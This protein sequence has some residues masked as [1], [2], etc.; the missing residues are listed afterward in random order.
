[1][2]GE[3]D[4]D[5]LNR[6][7]MDPI[8]LQQYPLTRENALE[9]FSRS[10]FYDPLSNNETLRM[11]GAGMSHLTGMI[12]VEFSLDNRGALKGGGTPGESGRLF[13][14][15]KQRRSSPSSVHVLAVYYIL[16]GTVYQSP[17]LLHLLMTKYNRITS[18]LAKALSVTTECVEYTH[19]PHQ[20]GSAASGGTAFGGKRR[21]FPV[22]TVQHSRD[23]GDVVTGGGGKKQKIED[24]HD[25]PSMSS[26]LSDMTAFAQSAAREVPSDT[27]PPPLTA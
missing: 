26:C 23:R 20:V 9:Y 11:Q 15:K 16:D 5:A 4:K 27:A 14:V 22:T 12:G 3:D 8:F 18:C 19:P 6:S 24:C 25:F 21:V 17:S 7:F 10:P 13:R 1:M 2:S